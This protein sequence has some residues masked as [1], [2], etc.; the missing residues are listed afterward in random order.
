MYPYKRV[1]KKLLEL[2]TLFFSA[3][4]EEYYQLTMINE[5]CLY[6]L[7]ILSCTMEDVKN[8]T[9]KYTMKNAVSIPTTTNVQMI[10]FNSD[11]E[12]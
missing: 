4:N 6:D 3:A 11:K 12:S 9:A 8:I 7:D 2:Y 10:F 5:S 1:F